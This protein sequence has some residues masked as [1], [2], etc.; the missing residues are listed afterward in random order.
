M[1]RAGYADIDVARHDTTLTVAG[2]TDVEAAVELTLH[3]GPLSR[4]LVPLPEA[5]HVKV[6]AALRDAFAPH[7]TPAGVTLPASTWIATARSR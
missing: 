7:L 2:R 6:R 4:A 3:V 1:E 5:V